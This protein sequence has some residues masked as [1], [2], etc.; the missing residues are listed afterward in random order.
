MQLR[1]YQRESVEA[2][3]THLRSRDDNPCVVLP[4]AA[5]KSIVLAEICRQAITQ[6]SG[7]VLVVTHVKELVEQNAAKLR[8]M[9]PA[10]SVGV[11][12]AGLNKRDIAHPVIAAG[13]QS[14][15]RKACDLGRF[16]LIVIDEAHLMPSPSSKTPG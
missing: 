8:D 2:V 16:D 6:W 13:I 12:S 10:A 9:L 7:R 1:D 15:Y 3:W 4:T 11:H 14:V 5:G